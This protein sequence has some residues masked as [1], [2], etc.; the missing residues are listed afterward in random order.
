MKKE[1]YFEMCEAL[2]TTPV[3]EEIPVELSD[4]PELAQQAVQ[5]YFVMKDVWD[6]M[7]GNYLGKDTSIVFQLFDLY[8]VEKPERLLM[9]SFFQVL[10]SA[11]S[12]L[13]KAKQKANEPSARKP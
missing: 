10:D 2:G 8:D 13:I 1:T 12:E 3:D 9:M 4:L 11:R 6:P 7:G 5:L